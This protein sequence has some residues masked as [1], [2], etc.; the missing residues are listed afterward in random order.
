[1]ITRTC[2]FFNFETI[3]DKDNLKELEETRQKNEL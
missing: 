3:F 1:M 2:Y